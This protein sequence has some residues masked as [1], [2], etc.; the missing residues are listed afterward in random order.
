LFKSKF[1]HKTQTRQIARINCNAYASAVKEI[2][3]HS[4]HRSEHSAITP[5][6]IFGV[7]CPPHFAVTPVKVMKNQSA[8]KLTVNYKTEG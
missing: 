7:N 6:L 5:T 2:K 8:D 4:E 1:F 3:R